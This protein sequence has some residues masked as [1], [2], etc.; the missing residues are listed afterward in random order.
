MDP[1]EVEAAPTEMP[2]PTTIPNPTPAASIESSKPI[3]NIVES[4]NS[5]VETDAPI[6]EK[7]AKQILNTANAQ[8]EIS[9][10][11]VIEGNEDP[12]KPPK[13]KKQDDNDIMSV[14]AA[15]TKTHPDVSK[16][17]QTPSKTKAAGDGFPSKW[18]LD[19][20]AIVQ[21]QLEYRILQQIGISKE[22]FDNVI[23]YTAYS[24]YG[25]PSTKNQ[26]EEYKKQLKK[27]IIN[28]ELTINP[29]TNKIVYQDWGPIA[30]GVNS[31]AKFFTGI[32]DGM[33]YTAKSREDK[34]K[35]LE[36][37]YQ[38]HLADFENL[39]DHSTA[40]TIGS[41]TA[42]AGLTIGVSGLVGLSGLAEVGSAGFLTPFVLPVAT[43]A[44]TTGLTVWNDE[45]GK[46]KEAYFIS[47]QNNADVDKAYAAA[48]AG[49]PM[50]FTTSV[51]ANLIGSFIGTRTA[52]AFGNVFSSS[53]NQ[54]A[55]H[56]LTSLAKTTLTRVPEVAINT[57]AATIGKIVDDVATEKN[58]GVDLD[59]TARAKEMANVSLAS[60][61]A[62]AAIPSLI[63]GGKTYFGN[64]VLKNSVINHLSIL[65]KELV[66]NELIS[67][68]QKGLINEQQFQKVNSDLEEY[69]K[70]KNSLPFVNEEQAPT[71]V[72]LILKLKNLEKSI[73][74][75][76][77]DDP[78]AASV[79]LD[80]KTVKQQISDALNGKANFDVELNEFTGKPLNEENDAI[81]TTPQQQQA[82][83][84]TGNISQYKGTEGEQAQ[85][86][87]EAD[88]S[89]RPVGS[90]TQQEVIPESFNNE[91]G[92]VA[93]NTV[94]K[95]I[96]DS[97][98]RGKNAEVIQKNAR[99]N[100]EKSKAFEQAD[101]VTRNK[102]I[103][104]M[105]KQL[106]GEVDKSAP[107][108]TRI[109]GQFDKEITIKE[110]FA[111]R[112]FLKGQQDAANGAVSWIKSA[113]Q[114]ISNGLNE[115]V[116]AGKI[117]TTQL[118]SILKKYDAI[119]LQNKVAVN[120]FTDYVSNV[121]ND[122]TYAESLNRA[123]AIK[124]KIST[125]SKNKGLQINMS[126][127]AKEFLSINPSEVSDLPTYME[128]A[129]E[130]F[131]GITKPVK[132][133]E[134]AKFKQAFD[135]KSISD[136]VSGENEII[137]QKIK[138]TK[139]AE[140]Q[141]LVDKGILTKDMPFEDMETIINEIEKTGN[142]NNIPDATKRTAGIR[143]FVNQRVESL[144]AIADNILK[145][146]ED[147]FG[148][149]VDVDLSPNDRKIL[150]ELL[151]AGV[152]DMPIQDAY[153][154]M[155]ALDN[156]IVNGKHS[157]LEKPLY[158]YYGVVNA[159]NSSGVYK[160]IPMTDLGRL[161][162]DLG[163]SLPLLFNNLFGSKDVGI[164]KS[165]GYMDYYNS[166]S[167]SDKISANVA[168]EF[169]TMFGSKK[170]NGLRF[171]DIDNVYE[172]GLY[173]HLLRNSGGT[174]QEIADEFARRVKLF[175]GS[176]ENLKS[177]NNSDHKKMAEVYQRVKM[178]LLDGSSNIDDV[179]S[180]MDAI[181][182]DA[183]NFWVNKWGEK[184]GEMSDLAKNYYNKPLAKDNNYTPDVFK[185]I[186][187][188]DIG[189]SA[190]ESDWEN[191]FV[192]NATDYFPASE[193]SGLKATVKPS[194]VGA[195]NYI[196]LDFF[197]DMDSKYVQALYDI[198]GSK[199]VA[200]MKSFINSPEYQKVFQ[201]SPKDADMLAKRVKGYV[202]KT[203]GNYGANF[204]M[205][206]WSSFAKGM[207]QFNKI[208]T[209]STLANVRQVFQQLTPMVNAF[210]QTGRLPIR[211]ALF[212]KDA[213][214]FMNNSG[215]DI[216][217]TNEEGDVTFLSPSNDMKSAMDNKKGAIKLVDDLATTSLKIYLQ[218]PDKY[219]RRIGWM[220]FYMKKLS[221]SGIDVNDIDWATHQID[222]GAADYAQQMINVTQ[223][224]VQTELK[225]AIGS[226][227]NPTASLIK[228]TVMPLSDFMIN[229]KLN[230]WNNATK[231][232]NTS[233]TYQDRMAAFSGLAGI[234]AE[235]V[236][237][238]AVKQQF[239]HLY[240]WAADV[241]TDYTPSKKEEEQR[242]RRI[243]SSS[244]LNV[245]TD[246]S[247]VPPQFNFLVS[248][249]SN[250]V[251]QKYYESQGVPQELRM[252]IGG[253]KNIGSEA[254]LAGMEIGAIL[255]ATDLLSTGYT[256]KITKTVAGQ[257]EM[258][259]LTDADKS[260][261][262]TW[263]WI[264]ALQTV[265]LGVGDTRQI[266][267]AIR[268]RLSSKSMPPKKMS[269]YKL[270]LEDAKALRDMKDK[271][272]LKYVDGKNIV[273]SYAYSMNISDPMSRGTYLATMYN[274]YGKDEFNTLANNLAQAKNTTGESQ[275]EYGI[276]GKD[277]Y[278]MQAIL[279]KNQSE[280]DMG[281]AL[282]FKTPE[283]VSY[284]LFEL[285]NGT[286]N[287]VEF[288]RNLGL[289]MEAGAISKEGVEQYSDYLKEKLPNSKDDRDLINAFYNASKISKN[290]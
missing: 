84:A 100:L 273:E 251:L 129:N 62:F 137:S 57:A 222:D 244:A 234:M 91:Q 289:A 148:N 116:G 197:K 34:K 111:L 195:D 219:A 240:D 198:N 10:E 44:V 202:N 13:K 266:S 53:V 110:K 132:T 224:V 45:L 268:N 163:G 37:E 28:Q 180:K 125:L 187:S 215:R 191:G 207:N 66:N 217:M 128:K 4:A 261:A 220:A 199:Y 249:G 29:Q 103:S 59:I 150:E 65:D 252:D 14:L 165:M 167:K 21:G 126:A 7:D 71:V 203:R 95:V 255:K 69:Q 8:G 258:N 72:G 27:R 12:T 256:G 127:A 250:W 201:K 254:G 274:K 175:E 119:N 6:T 70:L 2:A 263:G 183:V 172:M 184:Y 229:Q 186:K 210:V 41:I 50:Y 5:D 123:N 31:F 235:A 46:E 144:S 152:K 96:K 102:M 204:D 104:D 1:I 286:K 55:K 275:R 155:D 290:R 38:K 243:N 149:K 178:K 87:N 136:Y 107:M 99:I 227:K 264:S 253:F 98:S 52:G 18:Q 218:K 283:A 134:G 138:A 68:K 176:I 168:K 79:E 112:R 56:V 73:E 226:S 211:T 189:F 248:G 3:Q 190:N 109:F 88:S 181:N 257:E 130:V 281:Y 78:Y 159:K 101:D 182:V 151:N 140:Y 164:M 269:E 63:Q 49:R 200:Q 205:S 162:Y 47:R 33:S 213:I 231:A 30:A 15:W 122:A 156:F 260:T 139:M 170:P 17:I 285:R 173:A 48:E 32:P 262:K 284:K 25:T 288:Y 105:N 77:K 147:G 277:Y 23:N 135:E 24:K 161:S 90:E 9:E 76:P 228:S 80:V 75:L 225:G 58:T 247:F 230:F 208:S 271:V 11:Q 157:G 93:W 214:E 92:Q 265:G 238:N 158:S 278:M 232:F 194:E 42:G 108:V 16:S 245:I 131:E 174:E 160:A 276:T 223:N 94:Q 166:I 282:S 120:K 117:K 43:A 236:V 171:D 74:V 19:T 35:Y 267:S 118:Q 124:S 39:K 51:G 272:D 20:R 113:R 67:M 179:R 142:A 22:Q 279:S 221:E 216:A 212:N 83:E 237:F 233:S 26:E 154:T 270:N 188:S 209:A 145:N 192:M 82:S 185:K 143:A 85:K 133:K 89:N 106:F 54:S 115:L 64:K 36:S 86:A 97:K 153:R 280:I 239:A 259:E 177:S 40:E 146:G 121:I 287:I 169:K 206:D 241:A 141:E 246:L 114:D 60:N 242:Q 81:T 61:V 196:S 193:S